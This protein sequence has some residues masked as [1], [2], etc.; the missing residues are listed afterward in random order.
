MMTDEGVVLF[1]EGRKAHQNGVENTTSLTRRDH[2]HI[3]I[4]ECLGMLAQRIGHRVTRLDVEHHLAHHFRKNLVLALL[5]E[6]GHCLNEWQTGVDHRRE[7]TRENDD[8][9][10]LDVATLGLLWRCL[11]DLDD[12]ESL[13]PQLRNDVVARLRFERSGAHLTC[14]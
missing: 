5:G 10:H 14:K 3:Q 4:A 2:V 7:L 13:A 8:V 11:I 12:I 6:N 9:A 1:H